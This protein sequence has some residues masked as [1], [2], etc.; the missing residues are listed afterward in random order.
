MALIRA[1]SVDASS[2]VADVRV[3]LTFVNVDA[4]VTTRRQRVAVATHALERALEVVTFT[5]A[6]N[7]RAFAAFVNVCKIKKLSCA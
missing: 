2:V 7:A 1:Q 6:A 3:A 5:V 4:R